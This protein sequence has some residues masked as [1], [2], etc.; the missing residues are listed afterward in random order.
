MKCSRFLSSPASI[1][2]RRS[3]PLPRTAAVSSSSD[4]QSITSTSSSSSLHHRHIQRQ[5]LRRPPPPLNALTSSDIRP[6]DATTSGP[7]GGIS[8]FGGDCGPTT[9]Q[10]GSGSTAAAA[11][12]FNFYRHRDRRRT[13]INGPID[14]VPE[15]DL[16]PELVS[17]AVPV[18]AFTPDVW[19]IAARSSVEGI[20]QI[21]VEPSQR[22]ELL[23]LKGLVY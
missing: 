13:T 6:N 11:M 22:G 17:E 21:D 18:T 20:Q 3:A 5:L 7:L 19:A 10:P 12:P 15:V 14:L 23:N 2:S 8:I 9:K 1:T 16:V 4:I